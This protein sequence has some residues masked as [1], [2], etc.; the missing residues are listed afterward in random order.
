MD[1]VKRGDLIALKK[2]IIEHPQLINNYCDDSKNTLLH[3]A[4]MYGHDKCVKFLIEKSANIYAQN[5]FGNTPLQVAII[6]SCTNCV[7]FL[8]KYS[9]YTAYINFQNFIGNTPLHIASKFNDII[10]IKLL[11]ENGADISIK[12]ENEE[13]PI[14]ITYNKELKLLIQETY[15]NWSSLDVKEPDY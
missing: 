6:N 11:I 14:D 7:E 15:D 8:I 10:F 2:Y 5:K 3:Y 4:S 13:T 12:N 1:I 9:S